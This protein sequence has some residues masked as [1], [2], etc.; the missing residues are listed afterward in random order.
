[1]KLL[2]PIYFSLNVSNF[3]KNRRI[4]GIFIHYN[5]C[6]ITY[7]MLK[8]TFVQLV[9]AKFA[10]VIGGRVKGIVT[11]GAPL[12]H[13]TH[14]FLRIVFNAP[15]MQGYGELFIYNEQ[16]HSNE[17]FSIRLKFSIKFLS[18]QNQN[19]EN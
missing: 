7:E 2:T 16:F 18:L 4:F 17:N 14:Q 8:I 10:D 19:L 9:F 11:G 5:S 3:Q 12:S 13:S 15:V 6:T 1:M